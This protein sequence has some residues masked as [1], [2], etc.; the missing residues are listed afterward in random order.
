VARELGSILNATSLCLGF[1]F[2]MVVGACPCS[3]HLVRRDG[4][5]DVAVK[6]L[7]S[8]RAGAARELGL[9]VG[10]GG[11][12]GDGAVVLA[13]ALGLVVLPHALPRRAV[14]P[15]EHARAIC[16]VVRRGTI[17]QLASARSV[18]QRTTIDER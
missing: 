8:F 18:A 16:D 7:L 15:V 3:G 14:L 11:L 1:L 5:G 6:I 4:G 12:V 10:D 13:L 9:P 2:V 17:S